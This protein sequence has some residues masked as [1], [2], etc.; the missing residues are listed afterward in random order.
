[1]HALVSAVLLRVAGL[2]AFDLDAETEPP[3][4]EPGEIASSFRRRPRSRP[5]GEANFGRR[6]EEHRVALG[7]SVAKERS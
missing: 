2:D 1:M 7:N 5:L 4:G 6:P 3:D